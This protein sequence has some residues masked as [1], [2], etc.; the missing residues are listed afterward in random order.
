MGALAGG[1]ATA[2]TSGVVPEKMGLQATT[3]R[4]RATT[5]AADNVTPEPAVPRA[6]ESRSA[7][8][9][10]TRTSAMVMDAP[11][12]AGTVSR[13]TRTPLLITRS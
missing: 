12:G 2:A 7:A 11:T 4:S 9:A 3:A 13:R 8:V 6:S 5:T 1:D 10:R